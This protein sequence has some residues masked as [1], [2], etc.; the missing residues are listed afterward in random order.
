V[1]IVPV[2]GWDG[3]RE[4]SL[5]GDDPYVGALHSA[6]LRLPK[7]LLAA[8]LGRIDDPD[9]VPPM[10]SVPML[11]NVSGPLNEIPEFSALSSEP[12]ERL[13]LSPEIGFTNL[14]GSNRG[15]A[16]SVPML[17]R[18]R[19]ELVPA[20]SLQAAMLWFDV[21]PDEVE[22]RIG[23]HIRLG[24]SAELPIDRAGEFLVDFRVPIARHSYPELIL[25]AR[26]RALGTRPQISDE[27]LVGAAVFLAR[28][29]KAA[30]KIPFANGRSG[31]EGQLFAHA[32]ATAQAKTA[33]RRIAPLFDAAL[34]A[35]AALLLPLSL[36]IR[37]RPFLGILI[38]LD[39]VY[40]LAAISLYAQSHLCLPL[41]LP[42]GLLVAGFI[43]RIASPPLAAKETAS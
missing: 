11:A 21:A 28:S 30:P 41:V 9:V 1:G 35:A 27:E 16:R 38:L 7:V 25:S 4:D 24:E 18:Y 34:V 10:A 36:K 2:L 20:F 19:G 40:L 42:T 26:E 3:E 17:F 32:L 37:W 13:R 12:S 23:R 31:T 15:V 33:P 6:V 5:E 43:W 14:P 8:R 39:A 22:V 29:D